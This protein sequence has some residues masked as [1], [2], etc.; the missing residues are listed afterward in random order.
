[1]LSLHCKVLDTRLCKYIPRGGKLVSIF[2]VI[3]LCSK[4]QG[5]E[6]GTPPHPPGAKM[7]FFRRRRKARI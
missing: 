6:N 7:P 1:M 5:K 3:M 2:V 4:L